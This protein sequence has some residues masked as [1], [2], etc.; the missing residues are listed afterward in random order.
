MK[1]KFLEH[2]VQGTALEDAL[3]VSQQI[4]EARLKMPYAS[5][6]KKD[7]GAGLKSFSKKILS[8]KQLDKFINLVN[9]YEGQVNNK[10]DASNIDAFVIYYMTNKPKYISMP[11]YT[12]GFKKIA[13]ASY[14]KKEAEA[15]YVQ[16]WTSKIITEH[17]ARVSTA[18]TL[19]KKYS[20]SYYGQ[21]IDIRQPV[22]R[23]GV[24]VGKTIDI[25][26]LQ[27]ATQHEGR[28]QLRSKK[29][30]YKLPSSTSEEIRG[31]IIDNNRHSLSKFNNLKLLFLSN[32]MV[33]LQKSHWDEAYEVASLLIKH[34]KLAAVY[35]SYIKSNIAVVFEYNEGISDGNSDQQ[36]F[37][38][39]L[40]RE[41]EKAGLE[42]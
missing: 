22:N 2:A 40:K 32:L 19:A 33:A 29:A 38:D 39:K 5:N 28:L 26:Q 20:E 35:N 36:I 14:T 37:I 31:D 25:K 1:N 8:S 24:I 15:L 3:R 30:T 18:E 6:N 16:Y 13:K 17:N 42:V 21:R 4:M 9:K 12:D 27:D 10:T 23:D 41:A 11:G 7:I 34:G